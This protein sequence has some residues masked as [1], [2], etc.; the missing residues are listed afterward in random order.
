M[1]AEVWEFVVVT[2]S[3]IAF[4]IGWTIGEQ[5][6]YDDGFEHGY[7]VGRV[8]GAADILLNFIERD[9]AEGGDAE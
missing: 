3:I 6:G 4:F 8:A 2:C 9:M 5:G 1:T 7:K